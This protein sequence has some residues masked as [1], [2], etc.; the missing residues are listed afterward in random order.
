MADLYPVA[1]ARIYMGAAPMDLQS[2]DFEVSDF[3]AVSWT[4]IDGWSQMGV[5]G[6]AAALI[7]TALINRNRDVKQKGT[8]NAGS[9]Q[10][11]FAVIRDD[12]GQIALRAAAAPSVKDNYPFRIIWND[13]TGSPATGSKTYFIGLVM[14]AQEAGGE[15]NTMQMLNATIE[16]NCNPVNVAAG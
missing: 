11:V 2:D 12:A 8:A 4:E 13:P 10:N 15:A 14:S 1:G 9:M 6:D 7:T 16:I 3:N 5:I